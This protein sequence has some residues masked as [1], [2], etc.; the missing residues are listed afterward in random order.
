MFSPQAGKPVDMTGLMPTWQAN[1]SLTT[2]YPE[3]IEAI[4]CIRAEGIKTALL[5]NNWQFEDGETLMNLDKSLFDV[6]RGHW[7]VVCSF[8]LGGQFI[9]QFMFVKCG[10]YFVTHQLL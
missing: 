5:T 2:V 7:K 4:Q 8:C 10:E 6:V 3:M 1:R 9:E